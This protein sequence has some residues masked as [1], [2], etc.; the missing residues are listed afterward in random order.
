MIWTSEDSDF[1]LF[2]RENSTECLGIWHTKTGDFDKND[3][4]KISQIEADE[5]DKIIKEYK[6]KNNNKK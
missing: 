5:I 4:M 6:L 2:F 3:R 1:L